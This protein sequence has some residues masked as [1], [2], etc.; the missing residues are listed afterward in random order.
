VIALWCAEQR[1]QVGRVVTRDTARAISQEN[2]EIVRR[3]Y[4]ALASRDWDAVF[5][6]THPDFA[7]ETQHQ[8]SHRGR[9]AAQSFIEDQIDT[10]EAWT[11]EPEEFFDGEDQV[12]VFVKVCAQPKD[13]S[14]TIEIKNGHLWTIQDG[15]ILLLS[16]FPKP[17]EA[18]EA[19]GLKE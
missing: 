9:D 3:V 1:L 4:G 17:G 14:A 2:V 12:V 7:I 19:A 5:S 13:S 10:F 11:A 15:S 6:D 16:T 18:L 8:G